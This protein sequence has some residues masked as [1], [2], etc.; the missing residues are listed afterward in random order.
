MAGLLSKIT[1]WLGDD[2]NA[3]RMAGIGNVLSNLDQGR[4]GDVSPFLGV[5]QQQ[6][7]QIALKDSLNSEDMLGKFSPEERSFLAGLPPQIAQKYI[8]ERIFA[9]PEATTY[10]W[11]TMPD[12]SLIRTDS[13]GGFTPMGQFA[14]PEGVDTPAQVKTL[15]WRA[16]QAGL[17]PG[18]PE[19]AQFMVEGGSNSGLAIDV[20]PATGAVSVRQGAGANSGKPL[21]EGQSKD[22]VFAT[23]AEGALAAL[24]G[25]GPDALTD[26][27][28]I[29]ADK[30]PLGMARGMQT[31][32]YQVARN[33]GD[34]FLQAILRKDT[35][36]AIT[37][38]E[39]DLYGKTYLPQPG[40]GQPVLQQKAQARRRALEA[41][42]AGMPPSAILAQERALE[43]SG[44]ETVGAPAQ[45]LRFNPAT[46]AFE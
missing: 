39:Q 44:S 41:L 31:D 26:R 7:D 30:V 46:G 18:T 22:A 20:D 37:S 35:G 33:A 12:G 1:G 23:R 40:D 19:Y 36:A 24:E 14:K 9:Q 45:R 32:Q 27:G 25:A 10:G 43:A 28:S 6:K 5:I 4:S 16:E 34:E 21:T 8:G 2:T 42:K 3:M 15:Q 11:Q 17:Q 38:Q 13:K 29:V